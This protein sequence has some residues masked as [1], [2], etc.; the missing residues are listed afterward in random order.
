MTTTVPRR[1]IGQLA[2]SALGLGCMG[3]SEFYG[4]R[5]EAESIATIHRALDLG[6][7]FLDTADVYGPFTNEQLGRARDPRPA[8]SRSSLATKFGNVRDRDDGSWLGIN[9]SPTTCAQAC[10]ASLKRLGVDDDR[11]L[12]PAPR[13]PDDADRGHGRRDG[14]ARARRARSATSA[15]RRRRRRRSAARTRCIR[16]RALQTEYSLWSRDPE[17]EL[18]RDVP[19]ARHRLRRLQPA[20]PRLPHRPDPARSTISRRTTGAGRIRAFRARTS[21]ATWLSWRGVE[22]LARRKGCTPAQLALAW[23]LLARGTE[24]VPIPGSTRVERVEEKCRG[25]RH[26]LDAGRSPQPS[27]RSVRPSRAIGMRKAA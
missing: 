20:R 11:P 13:R 14:R 15:C 4:P 5:D 1:Q 22:T 3:M 27:T 10:D 7:N 16:S 17:D 26:P 24:V 2:V 9:G 12:L 6:V 23:L 8:R 18:L 25:R 19:R 21:S